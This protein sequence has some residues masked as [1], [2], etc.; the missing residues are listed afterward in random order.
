MIIGLGNPGDDYVD[1]RHNVGQMAIDRICRILKIEPAN[2]KEIAVARASLAGKTVFAVKLTSFMNTSGTPVKTALNKYNVLPSNL[3]VIHDDL[4]LDF[5]KLRVKEGG[6]S[7]GHRGLSS[8]IA[9][10]GTESFFRIR[11]GIGR[12]PGRMDPADFVLSPFSAAEVSE[13]EITLAEAADAALAV[14]QE[15]VS[16]AMN[17]YNKGKA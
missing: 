9:A 12:P 3:I 16:T 5:A 17:R 1:T 15:G 10:L 11:I 4:D 7:G 2:D 6:S 8:I 13:M 14:V